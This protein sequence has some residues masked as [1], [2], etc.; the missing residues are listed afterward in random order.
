MS[1]PQAVPER[2]KTVPAAQ[3]SKT[4]IKVGGALALLGLLAT[5]PGFV[6]EAHWARTAHGFLWGFS[7]LWTVCLGAMLLIALHHVTKAVWSVLFRRV[8]ELFASRV[9]VVGIMFIPI[10]L[11]AWKGHSIGMFPWL[12]HELMES[13][14]ALHGKSAFLNFSAF[15]M[16]AVG[17]FAIWILFSRFFV[18]RSLQQDG[19]KGGEASTVKMRAFAPPFIMLFAVTITFAGI[20]WLMSLEPLWFSTMFGVYIFSGMVLSALAAVTITVL[21]LAKHGRM[22][23]GLINDNHIYNLGTLMFAFTVFWGYIAFSQYMLIWY[24]NMPEETA[25]ILRRVGGSWAPVSILL[26]FVRFI[27]PFVLLIS[28]SAKTNIQRLTQISYFIL[29]GQLLDLYWLIMPQL[30]PSGPVLGW[31]ELG[32]VLFLVGVFLLSL[33]PFLRKHK[34]IPVGDPLLEECL[35]FHL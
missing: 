26:G 17:F 13:N 18:G 35:C 19:G 24:A 23:S 2:I 1:A 22:G 7:F 3:G 34:P 10:W 15:T 5:A 32:P 16:R 8:M 20:D 33:V 12:N 30:H 29:F 4:L 27:I 11:I 31:Q 28:R 9:F 6:M 14:H 25:Y 21:Q